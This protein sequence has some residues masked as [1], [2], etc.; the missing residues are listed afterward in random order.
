MTILVR[1]RSLVVPTRPRSLAAGVVAAILLV[2]AYIGVISIAQ[3]PAHAFEQLAGDLLFVGA[4]AIG[5]G[6]QIALFAELWTIDGRHRSGAAVTAAGTGTS[7]AAMLACCAHHLA[8]L[9]PVIGLSALAV[10]LNAYR[11]PLLLLGIGMNLVGIIVVARQLRRAWEACRA[12]AS[13]PGHDGPDGDHR[14]PSPTAA[15]RG[16]AGPAGRSQG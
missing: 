12:P 10:F 9:L 16:A 15:R 14:V 4:I 2:A 13:A 1:P 7:T 6:V 8:D 11:T 5:F 3:G